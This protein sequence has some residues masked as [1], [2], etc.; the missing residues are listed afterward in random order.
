[1]DRPQILNNGGN[2]LGIEDEY[3]HVW[4]SRDNSFREGFGKVLDRVFAGERAERRRFW[5]GTV[6]FG[7]NSMA[8]RA[9]CGNECL[10]S[11]RLILFGWKCRSGG[12]LMHRLARSFQLSAARSQRLFA[13]G[14]RHP[15][16]R[17]K[18]SSARA[19][20]CSAV[21]PSDAAG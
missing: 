18:H 14:L 16:A 11:I 6:T 5:M 4:M 10:A 15:S 1:L 17:A 7:A 2:V 3:R 20:Q 8:T 13:S 19:A 9:V 21:N 12:D